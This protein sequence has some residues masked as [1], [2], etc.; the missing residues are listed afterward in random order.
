MVPATIA[1]PLPP[2]T[3]RSVVVEEAVDSIHRDSSASRSTSRRSGPVERPLRI[4]H[5]RRVFSLLSQTFVYQTVTEMRRQGVDAPVLSILRTQCRARPHPTRA[6]LRVPELPWTGDGLLSGLFSELP[7]DRLDRHLW[8]LQ[9]RWLRA[10]VRAIAPDAIVAHFGPDAALIGPVARS[11]GVPLVATFYGYDVSRLIHEAPALWR[12]VYRDLWPMASLVLGISR[13]VLHR[14]RALDAPEEKLVLWRIG[15]DLGRIPYRDPVAGW[16]GGRVECLHVGRLTAKKDPIALLRAFAAARRRLAPDVDL[17]LTIAGDG[18][19]AG[20]TRREIER[21]RLDRC[22]R[23]LG[24][25]PHAR[26]P[27]L[28]REAHIYV[29]HCR[30]APNGDME[31]L[32]LSFVE[33]AAAGLP[34]VSTRHDGI[35]DVVLHGR[36]GLLSSEGDVESMARNIALVAAEPK[37]WSDMGR[38]GRRHVEAEFDL[39]TTVLGL[40]DRLRS[41]VGQP[42]SGSSGL[43]A[44]RAAPAT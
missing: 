15:A 38:L 33:A 31:G 21:L 1:R 10:Q 4:L 3:G 7:V 43:S 37:L 24:P 2:S 5:F 13:H 44:G 32:G 25:V 42:D 41:L 11:L 9:R 40:I 20:R 27:A 23:L 28:L 19:L 36:T 26:V 16:D 22:T 8:P 30:T 18:E 29:Q 35:P 17:R 39:E 14:L 6:L 12:T 34:I